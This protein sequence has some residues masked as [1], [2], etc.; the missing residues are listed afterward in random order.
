V[1]TIEQAMFS[2][3]QE[4]KD[5]FL[6]WHVSIVLSMTNAIYSSASMFVT[7]PS[8]FLTHHP[9]SFGFEIAQFLLLLCVIIYICRNGGRG[10]DLWSLI[11]DC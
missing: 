2:R 6:G 7:T 10:M 8:I 4:Q 1:S 9:C 3:V 11:K 5:Y